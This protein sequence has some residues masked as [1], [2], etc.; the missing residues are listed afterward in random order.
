MRPS[1]LQSTRAGVLALFLASIALV[2]KADVGRDAVVGCFEPAGSHPAAGHRAQL[3]GF[4]WVSVEGRDE[5]D[6]ARVGLAPE[7][8]WAAAGNVKSATVAGLIARANPTSREARLDGL[9]LSPAW[10]RPLTDEAL[11]FGG[12]LPCDGTGSEPNGL[13]SAPGLSDALRRNF[14]PQRR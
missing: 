11:A 7:L 8:R 4:G 9:R 12:T 14:Q 10:V 13:R 5:A 2:G 6:A 3:S 1:P